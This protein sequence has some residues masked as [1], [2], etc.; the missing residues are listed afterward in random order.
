[1][2][3]LERHGTP[4][5]SS[6]ASATT[7]TTQP[8][9]RQPRAG[10]PRPARRVVLPGRRV[11]GDARPTSR[12]SPRCSSSA[13]TPT[14]RRSTADP[15]AGDPLAAN[16]WDRVRSRDAPRPTTRSTAR[17][18]PSSRPASTGPPGSPAGTC[19]RP[20]TRWSPPAELPRPPRRG[21]GRRPIGA[22]KA[23]LT[24][25][26]AHHAPYLSSGVRRRE[27]RVLRQDA[28][29]HP[30]LRPRWK[31]GV[32]SSRGPGRAVGKLYVERHFPP[33]AKARM[34]ELVANLVEAYRSDIEA[35]DWMAPRP[36][37]R[38][39]RSW[40]VHAQDRLPRRVARLRGAGDRPRRPRGQPRRARLRAR[41]VSSPSSAS[42][43][44]ATSG[45]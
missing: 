12:T 6:T 30:E 36:R 21:P 44:T 45:S 43:S 4:G 5:S 9:H 37:R 32:R 7:A 2:G 18:W 17:P 35:L 10:R 25:P 41:T 1:M 27:L 26:R 11:R 3:R 19:P 33:A 15:R 29:R 28:D 38:P 13:A 16:H 23:W 39:W 20:S 42:P 40:R 8:L 24:S 34:E 22:W 14:R 31:R